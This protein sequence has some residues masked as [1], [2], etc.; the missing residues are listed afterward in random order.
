M[1]YSGFGLAQLLDDVVGD[2]IRR[3]SAIED[4][5]RRVFP[6]VERIAIHTT[7]AYRVRDRANDE[8]EQLSQQDGRGIYFVMKRGQFRLR[9]AHASDGM[10]FVLAYLALRHSPQSPSLLLLEEPEN[11]IHPQR[12]KDLMSILRELV[13]ESSRTQVIMTTHS[14]YLV[15][16]FKPEE[17]TLCFRDEYGDVRTQRLDE[18]PIVNKRMKTFTLGEIWS[19]EEDVVRAEALNGGVAAQ[20]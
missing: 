10:L 9:A 3:Y 14:P 17:V 7:K 16:L 18:S 13:A 2:D 6:D 4:D 20:P 11:G 15:D 19:A 5:F 12:L 8:V 1:E